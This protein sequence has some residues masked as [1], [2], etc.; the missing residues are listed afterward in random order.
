MFLLEVT[1]SRTVWSRLEVAACSCAA[2]ASV[3]QAASTR[4]PRASSCRASRFPKPLSH[5]VIST[6]FSESRGT[7]CRSRCQRRSRNSPSSTATTY[8]HILGTGTAR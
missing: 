2:P 7:V 6:C 8:S 3:R 5:P 1:S 4:S